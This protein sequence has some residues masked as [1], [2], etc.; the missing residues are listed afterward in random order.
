MTSLYRFFNIIYKD[1]TIKINKMENIEL[2]KNAK[3]TRS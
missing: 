3:K 1:K 2:D